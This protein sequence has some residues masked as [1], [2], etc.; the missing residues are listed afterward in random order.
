[1]KGFRQQ[2]QGSRKERLKSMEAELQNSQMASRISQMLLQQLMQSSKAMS[3][4][5][6][7]AL[8]LINELQY[9]LLAVQEV[10][11]LDVSKLNDIANG[12]RLKDFEEASAKEDADLGFT[13][14]TV[15]DDESTVILTSTTAETDR[16]IFR[17]RIKLSESGVPDLIAAFKGREVGAKAV[18]KLN[19]VE[20]TVE[21]LGI[22]Q[23]AKSEPVIPAA[24]ESGN[25]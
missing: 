18:V 10:A 4:D 15:V 6:G 12:L 23:P 11:G 14:G 8:G 7:R 1:M 16:G 9:K 5:L 22:R 2:P 20:H 19:G 13:V 24:P 21:L 17:S 3:D 25:A